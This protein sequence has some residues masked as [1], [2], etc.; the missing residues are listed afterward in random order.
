MP[1]YTAKLF[2][3]RVQQVLIEKTDYIPDKT[4][5]SQIKDYSQIHLVLNYKKKEISLK[6]WLHHKTKAQSNQKNKNLCTYTSSLSPI[7]IETCSL[8]KPSRKWTKTN[9]PKNIPTSLPLKMYQ[10]ID[11]C[12]QA[13]SRYLLLLKPRHIKPLKKTWGHI[14]DLIIRDFNIAPAL[15]EW[16]TANANHMIHYR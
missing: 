2:W 3:Q 14:I 7:I 9:C 15:L 11:K 6:K 4:N 8:D 5:I 16:N 1:N 12:W 10:S 13:S